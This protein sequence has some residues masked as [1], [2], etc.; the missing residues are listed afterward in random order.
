VKNLVL[1]SSRDAGIRRDG[2]VAFDIGLPGPRYQ[3]DEQVI[4]F[5]RDL[6]SRLSS[7]GGVE[8]VGMTSH[9]PMYR[10][11]Y[12]GE[13]SIEGGNPWQANQA[14][15]VEYRWFYGDYMKTL[16]IPLV[17]GRL[18]DGRDVAGTRTVLINQ[19]MADKFW[20]GQD[21]LGR[22]FGQGND[23]TRWYEVAG[24]IGNV[25]SYGLAANTPYEFYRTIE[26]APFA[27]MTVVVRTRGTDPTAI[28]P[29]ARQVVASLDPALPV[30]GVQ[31]LDQVVA[32]SVGQPRLLSALSA[33]FAVLA[34]LL[35]MV[36]VYGAMAY[37]VRRQRREFGIRLA[38]GATQARLARLVIRRTLVLAAIGM[39]AGL[40]GSWS[41]GRVLTAMLNDV[42]PTD[43]AVFALTAIAMLGVALLAS[44]IPA[45]AAARTDPIVV[46]RDS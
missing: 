24:V 16:G 1:L 11:G 19:A 41:V 13:M 10:F 42:R 3:A 17:R 14:P 30:T 22:R 28:V 20:P 7:I 18:L 37:N 15:L 40:F 4:A 29:S 31:T 26:Q 38:L 43:P 12:N 25:R 8:S 2:V 9:L 45:R 46:L 39:A 27:A 34:G 6:Y 36:G 5:Y 32:A 21:P 44:A 23:T 33:L 35:A